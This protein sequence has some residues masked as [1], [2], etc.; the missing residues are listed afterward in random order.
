MK[1][2]VIAMIITMVR[3]QVSVSIVTYPS[4]ARVQI[5][6][7]TI[8]NSPQ[9]NLLLTPGPHQ[10]DLRKEDYAPIHYRTMIQE[11]ARAEL[12]FTFR[13]LYKVK[14]VSREKNLRYSIDDVEWA[15][16]RVILF[17][18][19]G[20]HKLVVKRGSTV[21]GTQRFTISEPTKIVYR[22]RDNH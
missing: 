11:A 13:P 7:R 6:G 19:E 8:G 14:F 10:F 22:F 15:E 16:K 18:E 17:L 20:E 4:E 2:L 21:I 1:I 9:F 5:D 12:T 3:A